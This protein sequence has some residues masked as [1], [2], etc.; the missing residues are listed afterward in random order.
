MAAFSLGREERQEL[1]EQF[2]ALDTEGRGTIKWHQ[3]RTVFLDNFNIECAETKR[4]FDSLDAD[5]DDEVSY[6]DFLAA[7]MHGHVQAHNDVLLKTFRR[8]DK[9]DKG[10]ITVDDLR[11]ILGDTFEGADVQEL[12]READPDNSGELWYEE[13]LTFLQEP[14][15]DAEYFDAGSSMNLLDAMPAENLDNYEFVDAMSPA[16]ANSTT[17]APIIPVATGLTRSKTEGYPSATSDASEAPPPNG[18]VR[19]QTDSAVH[20]LVQH[21]RLLTCADDVI[22]RLLSQTKTD[23]D[24]TESAASAWRTPLRRKR[25]AGQKTA[26][27]MEAVQEQDETAPQSEVEDDQ[28]PEDLGPA[29]RDRH[30]SKTFREGKTVK[31]AKARDGQRQTRDRRSKSP[32]DPA[33]YRDDHAPTVPEPGD[34]NYDSGDEAKS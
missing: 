2:L 10:F 27:V 18:L 24:D 9:D 3:L 33:N 13:I 1:Q 5:R 7:A 23:A 32:T 25:K 12:V 16:N 17:L 8:F 6:S 31:D 11:A 29:R 20:R 19:A 15:D 4:I 21:N 14:E 28:A 26:A 34:P 30:D 22:S